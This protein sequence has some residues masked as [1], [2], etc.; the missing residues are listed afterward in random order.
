MWIL[1]GSLDRDVLVNFL[2]TS[3]SWDKELLERARY[4]SLLHKEASSQKGP[5]RRAVLYV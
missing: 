5:D 3:F 1:Q 2:P 4:H